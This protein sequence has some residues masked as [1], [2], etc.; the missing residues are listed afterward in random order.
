MH[1][2]G[3]RRRMA[4]ALCCFSGGWDAGESGFSRLLKNK[5]HKPLILLE[6]AR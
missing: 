6:L 3:A 1:A 4:Q 2:E 5:S